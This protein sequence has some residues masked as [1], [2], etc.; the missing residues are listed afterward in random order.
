ME[1]AKEANIR[2]EEAHW[3]LRNKTDETKVVAHMQELETA[4]I[5]SKPTPMRPCVDCSAAPNHN[6]DCPCW[7]H[8]WCSDT[9]MSD[10]FKAYWD[11]KPPEHIKRHR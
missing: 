4:V 11:R 7:C 2:L 1:Q 3:W 8:V 10:N 9:G 5:K 6:E